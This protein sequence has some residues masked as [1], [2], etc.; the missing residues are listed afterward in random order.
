M[1][2]VE[3]VKSGTQQRTVHSVGVP[4]DLVLVPGSVSTG[5]EAL[6]LREQRSF[7][8]EG[9]LDR[10]SLLPGVREGRRGSAFQG[11]GRA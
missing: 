2:W 5:G 8:E 6:G 10:S 4:L 3:D 7:R 1:E 9:M 11:Q